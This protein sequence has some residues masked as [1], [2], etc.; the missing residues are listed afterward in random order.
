MRKDIGWEVTGNVK[1]NSPYTLYGFKLKV[2]VRDCPENADCNV[3]GED[4]VD[5]GANVPPSQ[6][7]SFQGYPML[8]HMPTPKKPTWDYKLIQTTAKTD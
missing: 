7:R 1:N 3:I 4:D 8:F 2:T 6:L 5:I